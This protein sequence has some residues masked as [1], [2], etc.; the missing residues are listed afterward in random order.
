MPTKQTQSKR[1]FHADGAA[2]LADY[3]PGQIQAI[4][5]DYE[6]QIIRACRTPNVV[7][8]LSFFSSSFFILGSNESGI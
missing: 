1:L 2:L 4:P 5:V 8:I 3:Y 6:K 7:L